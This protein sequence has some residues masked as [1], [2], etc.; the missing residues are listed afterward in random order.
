MDVNEYEK[1]GKRYREETFWSFDAFVRSGME[2]REDSSSLRSSWGGSW[3]DDV[4]SWDDIDRMV[5]EG[6]EDGVKS[7]L[8]IA[9]HA[10]RTIEKEIDRP[11]VTSEWNVYGAEVDIGRYMSGVPECMVDYEPFIVSKAG[12][13]VT[14]CSSYIYSA[15]INASTII[16]RGAAVM[17]LAMALQESQHSVEIWIDHTSDTGNT[18][19]ST[20]VLLKGANDSIDPAKLAFQ[21]CHP[22]VLR[23]LGFAHEHTY[24]AWLYRAQGVGGGYGSPRNPLQNLPEGTIYLDCI[25]ANDDRTSDP[26][27]FVSDTLRD[28]GLID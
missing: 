7:A 14:L 11:R 27:R 4:N 26:E 24:P 5:S 1:N 25:H 9:E 12:K 2:H 19:V 23:K 20:K 21:L 10:L 22:V 28:L 17:G 16:K 6:W 13:V 15:A 8:P 3:T 18:V